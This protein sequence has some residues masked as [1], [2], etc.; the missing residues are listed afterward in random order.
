M[1]DTV[2]FAPLR[3]D[4]IKQI[5]VLLVEDLRRRLGERKV[6]LE[7]TDAAVALV[8]E[9]GFDPVYGARP[10]RRFIQRQVETGVARALIAGQALE[11]SKVSV[12]V[13]DGQLRVAID[14]VVADA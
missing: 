7:L 14:G 1:D 13:S 6:T 10:L 4:E 8:A 11:G 12:D 3:L 5:V 9:E 2:L